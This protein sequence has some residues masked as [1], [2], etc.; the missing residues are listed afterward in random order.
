M[1]KNSFRYLNIVNLEF[2][3]HQKP[4][5]HL[6]LPLAFQLSKSKLAHYFFVSA[7]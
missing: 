7:P 1:N 2:A 3:M 5:D 4:L 6:L